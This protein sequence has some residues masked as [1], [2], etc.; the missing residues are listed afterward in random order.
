MPNVIHHL[1][2]SYNVSQLQF[3][4]MGTSASSF[5]G[6]I[7]VPFPTTNSNKTTN[8]VSFHSHSL[9]V[10]S[11]HPQ[12]H[13]LS[14]TV[15]VQV[16]ENFFATCDAMLH[17]RVQGESFGIAV[18]EFSVRNKPVVTYKG[19]GYHWEHIKILGKKGFPFRNAPEAIKIIEN[20]VIN[21]IPTDADYNGHRDYAPDK[22]MSVFK[23]VF[24]DPILANRTRTILS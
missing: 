22:V 5:R 2:Q 24:I 21:G 3:V 8:S 10:H 18:G 14:P 12:I 16:K 6:I 7:Q 9:S 20:F 4:F 11:I 23:A 15:N 19:G 13:F 17:A 1:L